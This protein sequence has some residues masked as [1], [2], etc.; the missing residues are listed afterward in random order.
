MEALK[1]KKTSVRPPMCW[2]RLE[3][4]AGREDGT[5]LRMKKN[6]GE[7]E[8]N[9]RQIFSVGAKKNPSI[10]QK[11]Q[12]VLSTMAFKDGSGLAHPRQREK[13]ETNRR[14]QEGRGGGITQEQTEGVSERR[15]SQKEVG[16]P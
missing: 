12:T 13:G 1:N 16:I 14:Q 6:Q 15:E 8:G 7:G 11:E 5:P 9:G 2:G 3:I 10:G 4:G